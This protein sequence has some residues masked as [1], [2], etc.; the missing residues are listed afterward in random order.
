MI[1]EIAEPWDGMVSCARLLE[2]HAAGI[3]SFGGDGSV[4]MDVGQCLSR[5]LGAAWNAGL[6]DDQD[7]LDDGL[8]FAAGA[9]VYLAKNHCFTDGNKRLA[10]LACMEALQ[11]LDVTLDVST[12][13]AYDFV[14]NIIVHRY[15]MRQVAV[16]LAERLVALQ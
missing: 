3:S 8:C 14:T 11:R 16:W 12:D 15:D 5:S 6:Y 2:L 4:P 13:E 7:G 10:W 9:L 1:S